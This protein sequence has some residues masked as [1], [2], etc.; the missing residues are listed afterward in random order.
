MGRIQRKE[1]PKTKKRIRKIKPTGKT[2]KQLR[3]EK[4]LQKKI[5]KAMYYQ[6]N[7]SKSQPDETIE[8]SRDLKKI[9][10]NVNDS[11]TDLTKTL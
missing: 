1:T 10:V 4:R 8:K 2:R 7:R 3:K 9:K 5:N 11:L 6:N